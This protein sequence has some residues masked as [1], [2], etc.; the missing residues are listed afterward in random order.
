MKEHFRLSSFTES[1]TRRVHIVFS[2]LERYR[3]IPLS[4]PGSF[5]TT[6]ENCKPLPRL[7][8]PSN[9]L[10]PAHSNTRDISIFVFLSHFEELCHTTGSR[11]L[12]LRIAPPRTVSEDCARELASI[13]SQSHAP[14]VIF[15]R[16]VAQSQT[17][18]TPGFP[19]SAPSNDA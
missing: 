14:E 4:L 1:G 5:L 19:L 10:A 3:C 15:V 6:F 17:P 8:T 2:V 13:G 18:L 12:E 7:P 11:Q 16:L 9:K